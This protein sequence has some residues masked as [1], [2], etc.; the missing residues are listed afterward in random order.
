MIAIHF[1]SG[2]K[3]YAEI[4]ADAD[5]AIEVMFDRRLADE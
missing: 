3:S 1:P 4:A 2:G 5:T